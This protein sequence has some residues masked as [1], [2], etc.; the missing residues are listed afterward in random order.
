MTRAAANR[1]LVEKLAEIVHKYPDL[2]FS[3]I[4]QNFDFVQTK[5]IMIDHPHHR[6]YPELV[7]EDEFY[8]ESEDLL[9]RVSKEKK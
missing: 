7:W 3:Q 4:L 9:E 2:R 8:L 6:A 1:K 5:E